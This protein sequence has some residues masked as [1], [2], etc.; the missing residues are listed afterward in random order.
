VLVLVEE[1]AHRLLAFPADRTIL[2]DF[3]Q[4]LQGL[5]LLGFHQV[6]YLDISDILAF[7]DSL[8]YMLLEGVLPPLFCQIIINGGT[9]GFITKHRAVELVFR[10]PSQGFGD[11]GRSEVVGL[12]KGEADGHFTHH[13]GTCNGRGTAIGEPS[14]VCNLVILDLDQDFHLVPARQR[15]DIPDTISIKLLVLPEGI[16]GIHKMVLHHRGVDPLAHKIGHRVDISLKRLII[17]G[18]FSRT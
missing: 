2:G 12:L 1:F 18:S 3:L 8:G 17:G 15:S 10:Q 6:L 7:T 13:G 5:C 4:L 14:E 16:P 11:R 9:Q